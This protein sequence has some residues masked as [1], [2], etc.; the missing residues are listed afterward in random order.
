MNKA[1]KENSQPT[2]HLFT[3]DI[4]IENDTNPRAMEQLLRVLNEAGFADFRIKSGIE[5]G[6]IIESLEDNAF[7]CE[8]PVNHEPARFQQPDKQPSEPAASP[9]AGHA[10]DLTFITDRIKMFIAENR[11]TRL[12]VNKGFGVKLNIPCRIINLDETTQILT[13][14]HVDEKQVYAFTL[15]EIDDFV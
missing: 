4:L 10:V 15:Y 12:T 6:R 5:M 1:N 13:V 3:V 2:A 9:P 14:Y 7:I 11:L 8:K